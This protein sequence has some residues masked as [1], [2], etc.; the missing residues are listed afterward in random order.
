MKLYRILLLSLLSILFTSC[1]FTGKKLKPVSS[2]DL[3]YAEA[4]TLTNDDLV[5]NISQAITQVMG[6]S[7]KPIEKFIVQQ[8]V[9]KKKKKAWREQW[10]FDPESS[11][12]QFLITFRKDKKG[13]TDFS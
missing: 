9:G 11:N 4:G 7:D 8:P 5:Q 1:A 12:E 6:G 2:A 13:F 3:V 10:I